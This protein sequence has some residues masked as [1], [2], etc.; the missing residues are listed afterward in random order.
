MIPTPKMLWQPEMKYN[1]QE[2][3]I[4]KKSQEKKI[5]KKHKS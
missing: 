4:P 2:G 5:I 3:G 1:R